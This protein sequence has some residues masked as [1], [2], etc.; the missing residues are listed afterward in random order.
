MP[1]TEEA[2][3]QISIQEDHQKR[4]AQL[5]QLSK[6]E[7]QHELSELQREQVYRD[8]KGLP[9]PSKNNWESALITQL[10]ES[11]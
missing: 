11:K 2:T 7:L 5:R 10:L 1:I 3:S 8:N 6:P 9:T 4:L